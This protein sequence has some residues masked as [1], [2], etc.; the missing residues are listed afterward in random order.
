M[1]AV[2]AHL[3]RFRNELFFVKIKDWESEH[4]FRYV[5]LTEGEDFESVETRGALRAVMVGHEF[6][7]WQIPAVLKA[8]GDTGIDALRIDWSM[9]RP[10]PAQLR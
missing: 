10:I 8:C 3:E 7:R 5:A 2:A 4:E 6:P 9:G 1:Q